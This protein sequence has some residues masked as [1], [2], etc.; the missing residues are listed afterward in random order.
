MML[1][2]T[3]IFYAIL[4]GLG[5]GLMSTIYRLGQQ[6]GVSVQTIAFIVTLIGTVYGIAITWPSPFWHAP[7]QVCSLG[8]ASGVSQ[9]LVVLLIAAALRHGPLSPMNCALF[10]G[11]ALVILMAR[12]VWHETLSVMQGIGVAAAVLCVIFASFQTEGD[13]QR[14]SQPRTIRSWL[15]YVCILTGLFVINAL[16]SVSFKY[17]GMTPV[18][19]KESFASHYGYHYITALYLSLGLCLG[20]HSLIQTK[21]QG[22]LRWRIGLGLVAG[23]G[24]VTGMS[25]MRLCASLPAVF[26]FPVAALTV[27]LG[28]ALVS[29]FLFRERTS[30]AWWAMMASGS[31]AGGCLIAD[32]LIKVNCW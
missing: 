11:F 2:P 20:L 13:P 6:Q 23:F 10:L 12:L 32:A 30:R 31:L 7:W 9:Y 24:S 28:G 14:D 3:L 29:V 18:S 15:L 8:F 1:T 19:G 4:A 5:Y 27:I 17:L 26:T 25:S 22:P 21:P 16:G